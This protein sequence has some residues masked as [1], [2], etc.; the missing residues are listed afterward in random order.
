MKKLLV[1]SLVLVFSLV[2]IGSAV[3][4]AKAKPCPKPIPILV[5]RIPVQ[6]C[7]VKTKCEVIIKSKKMAKITTVT[8]LC[9]KKCKGAFPLWCSPCAPV[10]CWEVKTMCGIVKTGIYERPVVTKWTKVSPPP[11]IP[12]CYY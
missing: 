4:G 5:K 2:V 12:I 3:A 9:V 6:K 7:L 10:A 1:V 11:P 8:P